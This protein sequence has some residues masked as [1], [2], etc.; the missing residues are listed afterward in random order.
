MGRSPSHTINF[1]KQIVKQA[2]QL[3]L[4]LKLFRHKY[5]EKTFNN[6][7]QVAHNDVQ[8]RRRARTYLHYLNLLY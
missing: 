6:L 4:C 7:S 2:T 8:S 3:H 5:T 1:L